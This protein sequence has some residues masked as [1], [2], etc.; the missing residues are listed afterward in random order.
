MPRLLAQTEAFSLG[1]VAFLRGFWYFFRSEFIFMRLYPNVSNFS[2][3]LVPGPLCSEE[4]SGAAQ[5]FCTE[6]EVLLCF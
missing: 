4:R 1:D 3:Q 2:L 6:W 5:Q